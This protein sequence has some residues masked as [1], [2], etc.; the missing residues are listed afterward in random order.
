M[1]AAAVERVVLVRLGGERFAVGT[2]EVEEVVADPVLAPLPGLPDH[3]PGV[4]QHRGEWLPV[5]DAAPL[6][7]LSRDEA[8]RP[9][10]ALVVSRGRV[11]FALAVDAVLRVVEKPPAAAGSAPAMRRPDGRPEDE[12]LLQDEEGVIA[13]LRPADLFRGELPEDATEVRMSHLPATAGAVPIVAFRL[14]TD[15]FGVDVYQ[16]Q[17]VI[18]F[19]APRP[20]PHAPEFIEGVI[21]VRGVIVPVVDLRKRF[22][23]PAGRRGADTRVLLV[24]LGEE[25]VGLVV[26]EVTEVV[27]VPSTEVS[28]PPSLF[29]GLAA[30]YIAGLARGPRGLLILLRVDQILTS[31]ERL[32]LLG[33]E[34]AEPPAAGDGGAAAPDDARSPARAGDRQPAGADAGAPRGTRRKTRA[35]RRTG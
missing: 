28:E 20:V 12:P 29:R 25:R 8:A 21:D 16:V 4:L 11:R 35:K 10:A 13:S 2:Q 30:R 24:G 22:E 1:N 3:T 33:A 5:I 18:P 34:A 7:G 23:L 32:A 31:E 17:E 14:G 19:E 6:L 26:D 15:E 27:R 9:G